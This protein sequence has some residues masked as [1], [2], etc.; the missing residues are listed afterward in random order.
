MI[1]YVDRGDRRYNL[2]DSRSY[3]YRLQGRPTTSRD[4]YISENTT[5]AYTSDYT[6]EYNYPT[7]MWAYDDDG[8]RGRRTRDLPRSSA[9]PSSRSAANYYYDD[10]YDR[11]AY[12]SSRYQ[13]SQPQRSS[14]HDRHR[15]KSVPV[16]D[17]GEPSKSA[18]SR[19]AN[20][21]ASDDGSEFYRRATRD[22]YAYPERSSRHDS[23]Q[24]T[25]DRD[26]KFRE[27]RGSWEED[28]MKNHRRAK[29]YSP[30]R[31]ARE[32]EEEADPYGRTTSSKKSSRTPQQYY[33]QD[34]YS[35]D[36]AAK[37]RGRDAGGYDYTSAG[38]PAPPMGGT[39]AEE[40]K[41][42]KHSRRKHHSSSNP[43]EDDNAATAA[44]YGAAGAAGAYAAAEE[45][46]SRH[47]SHHSSKAARGDPVD[48]YATSS[49]RGRHRG[50]AA[51]DYE[52]PYGSR[53]APPPSRKHRQSMPPRTRSR[54][55]EED[56]YGGAAGGDYDGA[57]DPY[58]STAPPR[59]RAASVNH[60]GAGYHG[61]R[62]AS[63]RE[64]P[65]GGQSYY[66]DDYRYG[67][68]G[69][70]GSGGSP[71]GAAGG[72]P[73]S[74]KQKGKQWQKQA[75][76]LFMTHAVP[77]IKKEAVPFLTKAAQAYFEQK[78]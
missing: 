1:I 57:N 51:E 41:P 6:P 33:E 27:K 35:T 70:P 65:R 42:S 23:E 4:A 13:D 11:P 73:S 49:S 78:R 38:M 77:V 9:G 18:S 55:G 5:A 22:P 37:T 72:G 7:N 63:D 3:N 45:K 39:A 75:G 29:S 20:V 50:V 25:S 15:R 43:Y 64:R 26:R 14:H 24:K 8:G 67:G 40:E 2:D 66:D 28:E 30:K 44:G 16:A 46:P 59:R 31:A 21:I 58:Y 10:A 52:D 60:G 69:S 53:S 17:L 32:A 56:P 74:K 62:Y 76:K 54:Y 19:H 12:S 71:S 47:R 68:R 36:Y 48:P 61:D 34:P